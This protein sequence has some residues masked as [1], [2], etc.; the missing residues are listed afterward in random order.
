MKGKKVVSRVHNKNKRTNQRNPP[1]N[2]LKYTGQVLYP[3]ELEQN[4]PIVVVARVPSDLTS[5]VGSVIN[6]VYGSSPSSVADWASLAAS[7][8][9]YRV[10]ATALEFYPSNKYSKTTTLTKALAHVVSRESNSAISNFGEAAAYESMKLFSL[11]DEIILGESLHPSPVV[12]MSEVAEAE[13][14]STG[15]PTSFWYH[16]LYTDSVS[17]STTYGL[18][19]MTYRIQFRGRR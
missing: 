10:L 3:G 5:T 12:R 15:S 2:E 7:Y 17:A 16:K 14:L 9:E 1:S 13:W 11:D 19:V 4:A 18:I 8:S 6:N